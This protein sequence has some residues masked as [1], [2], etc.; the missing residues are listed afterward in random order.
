MKG[1][2]TKIEKILLMKGLKMPKPELQRYTVFQ[3]SLLLHI[4]VIIIATIIMIRN[5]A[6]DDPF[7]LSI[8]WKCE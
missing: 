6:V 5:R 1:S 7:P 2:S 8:S 4:R 3:V